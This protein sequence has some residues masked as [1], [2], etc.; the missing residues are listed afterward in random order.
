MKR[1]IARLGTAEEASDRTLQSRHG[2]ET[3]VNRL[4]REYYGPSLLT[5][6]IKA[7]VAVCYI[8]YISCAIY[9]LSQIKEGLNPKNLVRRSFYLSDFY[10]FI[11]ET[12]WVE[13]LQMQVVVNKPPDLFNQT[14]RDHLYEMIHSFENTEYTMGRNATLLW[15]D[16]F[17]AKLKDDEE[18]FNIS[19][20]SSSAEWY[21]RCK[22]W[23]LIAGGRRLWEL[24][25]DW[26]RNES[27]NERG[28]LKAFRFQV[29]LR[30]YRTP[31]DHTNSCKLMREI[32][33]RFAEFNVT[34]FHEYYPFADQYLELKPA[35][36]RNCALAVIC[37]L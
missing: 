21:Q 26:H 34:T 23:L 27:N 9:G 31:T 4:F 8:L 25:M 16:A 19:L 11:D 12:F 14:Q 13:G 1:F 7:Y 18:R 30:S 15:L 35:L 24:D 2:S 32:A 37:M 6:K 17:E 36:Y 10:V 5:N 33:S 20:P 28:R 29:G 3:F 22:E